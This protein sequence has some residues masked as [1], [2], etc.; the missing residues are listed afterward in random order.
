MLCLYCLCKSTPLYSTLKL[1]YKFFKYARAHLIFLL[2]EAEVAISSAS[3]CEALTIVATYCF[4]HAKGQCHLVV[5]LWPTC[6]ISECMHVWRS[7]VLRD[8]DVACRLE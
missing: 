1:T 8:L 3:F 5:S 6:V 7:C 2:C 4:M